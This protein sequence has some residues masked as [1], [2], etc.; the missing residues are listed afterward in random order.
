MGTKKQDE[1]KKE[2]IGSINKE[3]TKKETSKTDLKEAVADWQSDRREKFVRRASKADRRVRREVLH[4]G[5]ASVDDAELHR[6]D[7]DSYVRGKRLLS[8][9][10][11]NEA[12]TF[13]DSNFDLPF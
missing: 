1:N 7:V 2:R 8:R 6:V 5:T 4:D 12:K 11:K 3:T 13:S 9:K 10:V